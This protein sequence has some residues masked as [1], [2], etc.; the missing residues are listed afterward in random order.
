MFTPLLDQISYCDAPFRTCIHFLWGGLV[1][2]DKSLSDP[3]PCCECVTVVITA[4]LPLDGYE[5]M[6]STV[7]KTKLW[8]FIHSFN[9]VNQAFVSPGLS[10]KRQ[11]NKAATVPPDCEEPGEAT[12]AW[13]TPFEIPNYENALT[14]NIEL[15]GLLCVSKATVCSKA[16]PWLHCKSKSRCYSQRTS[17]SQETEV[18]V[19]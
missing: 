15:V 13:N 2:S 17:S 4:H 8:G 19:V 6:E 18:N 5:G 16:G 11:C 9:E 14:F 12:K 1:Q 7:W 10:S 3:N